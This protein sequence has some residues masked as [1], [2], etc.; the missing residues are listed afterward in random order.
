MNGQ[1]VPI[2]QFTATVLNDPSQ[3]R[4]ARFGGPGWNFGVNIP[5]PEGANHVWIGAQVYRIERVRYRNERDRGFAPEK[6]KGNKDN[7]RQVFVQ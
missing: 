3:V 1:N 2:Q 7:S 5:I 6:Y 4:I